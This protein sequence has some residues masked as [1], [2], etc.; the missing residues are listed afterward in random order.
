MQN[1]VIEVIGLILTSL[2]V[3]GTMKWLRNKS[4]TSKEGVVRLPKLILVLGIIVI[5]VFGFFATLIYFV[6]K[7]VW[8][9]LFFLCLSFSGIFIIIAWLNS[10]IIYDGLSISKRSF[11]GIRQTYSYVD[12][13]EIRESKDTRIYFGKQSVFIDEL[14]IGGREFIDFTKLQYANSHNGLGIPKAKKSWLDPFNGHV[15]RYGE[16]VFISILLYAIIIGF[17]VLIAVTTMPIRIDELEHIETSF[18]YYQIDE[19]ELILYTSASDMTYE[20]SSYDKYT[21]NTSLLLK[22]C[23]GKVVFDVYAMK[24][25]VDEGI[26]YYQV[27]ILKDQKGT[28][29]LTLEN[30]NAQRRSANWILYL[31]ASGFFLLWTLFMIGS[32]YVGRN[33]GRFSK[34]TVRLF[35]KDGYV[36]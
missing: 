13:T 31:L 21:E 20:I 2:V 16:F 34:K 18:S 36:H 5:I 28:S 8:V 1:T 32:I 14:A 6:S 33:P 23:D 9:A 26:P 15:D 27:M 22:Q 29:F 10:E 30:A 24:F 3:T 4:Q 17:A 12:I 11:F 19:G 7:E 25:N 35:F